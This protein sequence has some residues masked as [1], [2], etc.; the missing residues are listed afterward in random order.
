MEEDFNEEGQLPEE[1]TFEIKDE[2]K[3]EG[4]G[5]DSE[6]SLRPNIPNVTH[7]STNL[8]VIPGMYTIY[9][10]SMTNRE[11]RV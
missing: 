9:I 1:P 8:D 6:A 3:A 5:I 4:E 11:S 10:I 7:Q 2:V